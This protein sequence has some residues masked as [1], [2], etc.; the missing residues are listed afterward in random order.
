[1]TGLDTGF[2]VALAVRDHPLNPAALALFDREM[3]GVPRSMALTPQVLSEF[4]HVVT[5][6]KRFSAPLETT[7]ALALA[8]RLW[9]ARETQQIPQGEG[10]AALFFD[11]MAQHRLGRKRL[12]DTL[13][14]ATYVAGGVTRIVTSD[15]RDFS[16]YGALEVVALRA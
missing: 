9:G 7:A 16:S 1:M 13:L 8:E 14:A 10:A 6:A 3:R 15:W 4:V 2:L 5:D 12:L 11:W